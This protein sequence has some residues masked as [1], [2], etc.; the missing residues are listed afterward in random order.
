MTPDKIAFETL[1][2]ALSASLVKNIQAVLLTAKRLPEVPAEQRNSFMTALL[3]RQADMLHELIGFMLIDK[4][5]PKPGECSNELKL[6]AA[7]LVHYSNVDAAEPFTAALSQLHRM[8]HEI[9]ET[10]ITIE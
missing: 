1:D 3:V 10:L 2:L 4:T 5:T 9:P 6:L 8:G 7:L